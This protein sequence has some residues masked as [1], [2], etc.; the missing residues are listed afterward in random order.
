LPGHVT[1]VLSVCPSLQGDQR[2]NNDGPAVDR[3][4][5]P[6]SALDT[7]VAA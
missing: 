3:N 6:D 4:S 7:R 5:T 1:A 2:T